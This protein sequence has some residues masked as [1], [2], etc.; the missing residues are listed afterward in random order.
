[1]SSLAHKAR[2]IVTSDT[3]HSSDVELVNEESLA[4]NNPTASKQAMITKT[5][6]RANA[7]S[8]SV[9]VVGPGDT[10]EVALSAGHN[11][12]TTSNAGGAGAKIDGVLRSNGEY[13]IIAPERFRDC[14]EHR[15]NVRWFIPELYMSNGRQA[16]AIR[17]DKEVGWPSNGV[18]LRLTN[19]AEV[20]TIS[21]K[22]RLT[23]GGH[24]PIRNTGSDLVHTYRNPPVRS[25]DR[26]CSVKVGVFGTCLALFGISPKLPES[27]PRTLARVHAHHLLPTEILTV[28][29]TKSLIAF[30][31]PSSSLMSSLISVLKAKLADYM[32]SLPDG[33][34]EY[35]DYEVW[36]QGFAKRVAVFERSAHGQDVPELADFITEAER[37]LDP[38]ATDDWL[39]WGAR[40][41]PQR[42]ARVALQ[43]QQAAEEQALVEERERVAVA[44][45][46]AAEAEATRAAAARKSAEVDRERRREL[47]VDAMFDGSLDPEEGERQL[48]ELEAESV[49]PLPLFLLSPSPSAAA[50]SSH[51]VPSADLS[52]PDPSA[53]SSYPD[54]S[55][56]S[57]YPDP[58]ADSSYPDPSADLSYPDPS[59]A[60]SALASA[61]DALDRM[62]MGRVAAAA[63]TDVKGKQSA[64][65]VVVEFAHQRTPPLGRVVLP[66]GPGTGRMST[67]RS[68]VE[69]NGAGKMLE[70]PPELLPGDVLA[71]YTCHRCATAFLT[72]AFR[73]YQRPGLVSCTK[74]ARES[75]GCSFQPG[76]MPVE[77]GKGKSKEKGKGKSKEQSA[78]KAEERERP[79]KRR[80]V[81]V[82]IPVRSVGDSIAQTKAVRTRKPVQRLPTTAR[83]VLAPTRPSRA[84]SAA[85]P[86]PSDSS[87]LSPIVAQGIA[88]ELRYRIAVAEVAMWQAELESLEVRA[89]PSTS[90]DAVL[91]ED[92]SEADDSG[93]SVSDDFLPDE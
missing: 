85:F 75:K 66:L 62:S 30:F 55:A 28:P 1:M 53:D 61:T 29:T 59:A 73:C 26:P 36:G 63:P 43:Q 69:R 31:P 79:L 51:P 87:L 50:S 8:M 27:L 13:E 6:R 40:I 45:Q 10:L 37:G 3:D 25:W 60:D 93:R 14:A 72:K 11:T 2:P 65:A 52:H 23:H 64:A 82:V 39:V 71:N 70:D 34:A 74:C 67:V 54:P 90:P 5:H 44:E 46:E 57:S 33:A 49:F 17:E 83:A 68:P 47:L 9:L 81:E 78:P 88:S 12:K 18:R 7:Q 92:S 38:M 84:R 19:H 76:W 86:A 77:K 41:L 15:P 56:D 22:D 21:D 24:R 20:G 58:S 32:L 4:G 42:A 91:V 89:G 80:K 48:A 16:L 35:E